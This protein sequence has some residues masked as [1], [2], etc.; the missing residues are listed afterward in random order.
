LA[1]AR[2]APDDAAKIARD[3]DTFGAIFNFTSLAFM[4]VGKQPA[5]TGLLSFLLLDRVCGS[6]D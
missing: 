4:F 3:T 6:T 1:I 5:S 2:A